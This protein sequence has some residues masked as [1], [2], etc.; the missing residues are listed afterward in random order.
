[1]YNHFPILEG[2]ATAPEGR[3]VSPGCGVKIHSSIPR[4]RERPTSKLRL[5]PPGPGQFHPTTV[6][7]PPYRGVLN[8][9]RPHGAGYR[10][11]V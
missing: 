7:T 3:Q 8:D 10:Q 4:S 5:L 2:A 11:T 9:R 1:M 6:S